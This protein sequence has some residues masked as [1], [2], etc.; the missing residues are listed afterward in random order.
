MT[1]YGQESGWRQGQFR[2]TAG[3]SPGQ[4][5]AFALVNAPFIMP[6]L[7]GWKCRRYASSGTNCGSA[8]DVQMKTVRRKGRAGGR[9]TGRNRLATTRMPATL[10]A[11][12]E[13]WA[14]ANDVTRAD[15]IRRLV[16]LGLTARVKPRQINATRAKELAAKVIDNLADGEASA[17]DRASRKSRLLKGPEEFREARVD[18][19]KA[20]K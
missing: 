15:A 17:D 2:R 9:S 14:A 1:A 6:A 18:R 19:P 20:R 8:R 3:V 11:E 16:E 10:M 7:G 13:V 4:Q 12:V 5:R